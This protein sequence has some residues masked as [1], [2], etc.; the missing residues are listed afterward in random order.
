MVAANLRA[1][2]TLTVVLL[3]NYIILLAADQHSRCQ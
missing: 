2:A 1:L 3:V